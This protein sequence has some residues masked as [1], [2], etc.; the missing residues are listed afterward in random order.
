MF[1]RT[2]SLSEFLRKYP[3]VSAIVAIHLA[4]YLVT[5]LLPGTGDELRGYLIGVNY[6][7]SEGEWWRLFTPI[8]VHAGLTHL[9]FNSFS[10]VIFAPFLEKLLGKLWFILVYVGAGLAGNVATFLLEG[11]AYVHV[12][13]SGA[14]YGLFGFY[15]ALV[16]LHRD[17][18]GRQN[19]NMIITIVSIGLVFTFLQSNI[20]IAA[21]IFGLLFGLIIGWMLL[22]TKKFA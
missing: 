22:Q 9:L 8:I 19:R 3:I 2:E 14:I 11:P 7:I 1:L 18:L 12:G 10:L 20:N 21:H 5:S 4:V 15:I 17:K 6:L 13:S 16:L